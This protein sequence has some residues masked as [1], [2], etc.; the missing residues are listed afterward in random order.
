MGLL[1]D[2][3]AAALRIRP[4]Y[5]SALE[6]GRPEELPGPAYA[7]GF[8]RAYAEFLGLDGAEL[9]RR[10]KQGSSTF[11]VKPDL[12][13][14]M[15]LAERSIP[16]TGMLLVAMILAICGYGAWYYLS[17]VERSRPERVTEVPAALL[18]AEPQPVVSHPAEA[19]ASTRLAAPA[20]RSP[21]PSD[22]SNSAAPDVAAGSR[23]P[24]T[25][26]VSV[27][28]QRVAP[29]AL[30]AL[31]ANA[32]GSA[33]GG[34]SRQ[35]VIRATADSWVQIRD[36]TRAVLFTRI[37][38]PGD[39]YQVPEGPGFS[40]QTGNAGGLEITVDGNPAP[41]IGRMGAV[42]RNVPLDPQALIAGTAVRE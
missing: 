41:P 17:T 30:N 33:S 16:G 19:A 2:D 26:P 24:A 9:V 18:P 32:Q 34:G 13:F 28:Q 1:L 20:N 8:V 36:G 29:A 7:I 22:T 21:A 35:V 25:A 3:A 5:L 10:F 42:R 31:A 38:K 15:A 40:M 14:P 27:E 39:T 11:A 4:A 37:M 12:S 23:P 6:E